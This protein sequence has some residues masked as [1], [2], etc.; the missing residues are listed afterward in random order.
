[1]LLIL[2][3]AG[4]AGRIGTPRVHGRVL[5]VNELVAIRSA[6]LHV[7]DPRPERD[8]LIAA[9]ALEHGLTVMTRNEADFKPTGVSLVNRSG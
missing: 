7:P 5:P 6:R 8:T 9:T 1:M 3:L 2:P 4:L